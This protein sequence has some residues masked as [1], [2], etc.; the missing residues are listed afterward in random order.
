MK[1]IDLFGEPIPTA[2]HGRDWTGNRKGVFSII[3]ASNHSLKERQSEDFYATEPRAVEMLCDLE[4]FSPTILEP[5]VGH[6]HI[7]EV[8]K[9]R[10]YRVIARDLYDRGYGE[11][12]HDFRKCTERDMDYDIITNPPYKYA[13]EF[14]E[15]SLEVVGEGHK[16]AMFLKLTFLEGKNRRT[17]FEVTPPRVVYVSTSRLT[18]G[19]NGT[20]WMPSCVCY[21]WFVWEKG[22][23][24][25]PIIK[26]F[27]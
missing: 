7:A 12:G 23:K 14:V 4:K 8:L 22:F 16:V 25:D 15:K 26:W 3:G 20:E 2:N 5:S 18:C 19:K 6:G 24:G 1:E 17:M 27:N 13:Q 10:G 11:S 9:A 21:A